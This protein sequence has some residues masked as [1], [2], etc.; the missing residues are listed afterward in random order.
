MRNRNTIGYKSREPT[1]NKFAVGSAL[2][3]SYL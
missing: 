1:A 3:F 2:N